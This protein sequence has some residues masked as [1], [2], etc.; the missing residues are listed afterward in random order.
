MRF[1][2]FLMMAAGALIALTTGL[3]S[4]AGTVTL[5][6][7]GFSNLGGNRPGSSL[8]LL[9]FLVIPAVGFAIC[10][11]GIWLFRMGRERMRRDDK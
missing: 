9:Y 4:V 2:S 8:G 10:A 11:V 3:C 7:L 5:L 6:S 1:S